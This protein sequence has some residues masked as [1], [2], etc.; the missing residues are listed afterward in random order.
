MSPLESDATTRLEQ[1]R[2]WKQI[3]LDITPSAKA[4]IG[5]AAL[6]LLGLVILGVSFLGLLALQS[7]HY[8]SR[9]IGIL[10]GIHFWGYFA[11]LIVLLLDL[12]WKIAAHAFSRR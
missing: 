11:V 1:S 8:P 6:F 4:M 9:Y 3:S 10:E 7:L 2:F 5:D 12:I